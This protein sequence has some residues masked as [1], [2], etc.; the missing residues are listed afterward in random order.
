MIA[1]TLNVSIG[2]IARSFRGSRLVPLATGLCLCLAQPAKTQQTA[3]AFPPV[4]PGNGL[5]QHDF[6]YSGEGDQHRIFIVRKGKV[7]WSYLNE[8]KKGPIS[9]AVLM[10]N[11][12]LLFSYSAGV[13]LLTPDK[14]ILWHYDAPK[15]T[16]V[17]TAQPIGKSRVL[18]VQNGIPAILRVVNIVTGKTE[19]EFV[20]PCDDPEPVHSQFR[21]ARLTDAGTILVAH[22]K[23]SKVKEYDSRGKVLATISIEYPWSAVRLK[24]GNTLIATNKK[25][26]QELDPAG[27]VVWEIKGSDFP[28]YNIS[29]TQIATRLPNG[30]TLVNNWINLFHSKVDPSKLPVQALE[31]TPDK[32]VVWALREWKEPV[33]LGPAT[34]IQLLDQ[35]EVA[36]NVRFG[37][38]K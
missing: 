31:F 36:E 19:R 38:F 7:V 8:D 9:D 33:Y 26:V 6:V 32:K 11:G 27:R 22:M 5:A 3:L 23:D 2:A 37:E 14:K 17:H 34:T 21:H 20:L 35:P 30:N 29:G 28:E 24:N 10:S 25:L 15:G 18:L 16:E 12:N 13:T 4:L 1:R